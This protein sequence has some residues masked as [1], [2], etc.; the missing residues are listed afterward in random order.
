[1]RRSILVPD[2]PDNIM[3]RR[4]LRGILHQFTNNDKEA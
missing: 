2:G 4:E 1:M 3:I